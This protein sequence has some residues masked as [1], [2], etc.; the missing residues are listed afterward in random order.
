MKEAMNNSSFAG[1]WWFYS[2]SSC[3]SIFCNLWWT[4]LDPFWQI[5]HSERAGLCWLL[6]PLCTESQATDVTPITCD[7][8]CATL[9]QM[10]HLHTSDLLGNLVAKYDPKKFTDVYRKSTCT[11]RYLHFELNYPQRV[12]LVMAC[13]TE[14][15]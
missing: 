3:E 4:K 7:M 5:K 12:G 2:M 15:H 14:Q 10:Y 13:S 11:G 9:L 6:L 8:S 1:G